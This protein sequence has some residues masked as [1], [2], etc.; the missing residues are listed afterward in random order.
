MRS[1]SHILHLTAGIVLTTAV[2]QLG[3]QV[4]QQAFASIF[5]WYTVAFAAYAWIIF[6]QGINIRYWWI[7]AL[8][9]RI[10]LLFA[11]PK[12]SDDV[13]RFIWDGRLWM[14]GINPFAQLPAFYMEPGHTVPGLT[15]EL[16]A[17]LNSPNYFTIYPPVNQAVFA[18]SAWWAPDNWA[19]AA[20]VMKLF[21]LAGEAGGLYA[22]Y[23]LLRQLELPSERWLWYALNPLVIVEISGNLHFEGIMIAFTLGSLYFLLKEKWVPAALLLAGGI[24]T[25]LWPVMLVPLFWRRLGWR[26]GFFF[27]VLTGLVTTGAMW[28]LFGDFF[29]QNFGN[30][31]NLYFKKFEFN[32]SLYYLLR[33]IGF[34]FKGY[35][36]IQ[37][38]GPALALCAGV[39]IL[40]LSWMSRSLK[41]QQVPIVVLFIFTLYFFSATIVHPWYITFL[42]AV[43]VLGPYRYPVL[44]SFLIILSY[45]AY[46]APGFKE[47]LWMTGMEYVLIFTFAGMEWHKYRL[48]GKSTQP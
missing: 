30:S 22:L 10:L 34:Q 28:P 45:A 12:L 40:Y 31:L 18:I 26:K 44:W 43:S 24:C 15:A 35:N 17:Q 6:S 32:A 48:S 29:V 21:L 25:K 46:A 33:W 7:F 20:V 42:V 4:E 38:L 13:F 11:F 2:F 39:V 27:A 5:G 8:G 19:A 47:P 16:F 14:A 23:L 3:Y 37:T 9:L 36:V 1:Y 41:N